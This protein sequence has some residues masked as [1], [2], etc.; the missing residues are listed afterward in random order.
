MFARFSGVTR[1]GQGGRVAHSWKVW[2]GGFW[3]EGRGEEMAE[4]KK[5]GKK[6]KIEM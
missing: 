5:R 4:R 6:K 2:G 1:S 3:K